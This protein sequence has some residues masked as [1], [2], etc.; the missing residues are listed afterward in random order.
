MR[1]RVVKP[2]GGYKA[3]REFDWGDGMARVLIA[4]GLVERVEDRD[5]E[6]AAVEVRVERAVQPQGKKR[7]K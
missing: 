6:T 7:N 1:V 2:F 5:Q 3:G 4:R